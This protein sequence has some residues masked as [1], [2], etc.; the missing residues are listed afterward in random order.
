MDRQTLVRVELGLALALAAS[1]IGG[2]LA[3]DSRSADANE[4]AQARHLWALS[5]HGRMLER[6]L[7]PAI[8]PVDLPEAASPGARLTVR[9]CIQCHYLPNPQMHTADRWK[10]LVERMV[11]RMRGE[12]NMGTLMKEMMGHVKAPSEAEV[13]VI[14][15]YLQKHGQQEIDPGHPALQGMTG[16]MFGIACSQCHA[17]PD[18]GRH[19]AAEWPAVVARM[20][21]H[22]ERTNLVVGGPDTRRVP[23]LE[24]AQIIRLLQRYARG[25]KTN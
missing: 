1:C 5:P 14:L 16:K 24:T 12:G 15:A 13:V 4:V 19:S 22:M 10:P 17:L 18:P 7:P 25:P 6:I 21:R 23:A 2:A 11:W 8:E 3:A 9:Y 20:K